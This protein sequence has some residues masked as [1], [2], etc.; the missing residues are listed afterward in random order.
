[1]ERAQRARASGPHH[2]SAGAPSA[3]CLVWHGDAGGATGIRGASRNAPC[4]T[5]VIPGEPGERQGSPGRPREADRVVDHHQAPSG[6]AL[7]SPRPSWPW[8]RPRRR[9]RPFRSTCPSGWSTPTTAGP[10]IAARCH[11][12]GECAGRPR[13]DRLRHTGHGTSRDHTAHR[14]AGDH[15][16]GDHRRLHPGRCRAGE[17]GGAGRPRGGDRRPEHVRRARPAVEQQQRQG[18]G[19]PQRDMLR[20]PTPTGS[21]SPETTTSSRATTSVRTPPARHRCSTTRAFRSTA[22]TTSSAAP[23]PPTAT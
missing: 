17:Q 11:H 20:P 1:M 21:A 5:G 19:H 6:A 10:G 3:R 4:R 7:C 14:S 15:G 16:P 23:T 18:T 2:R 22:R 9:P 8:A 12:P 13:H